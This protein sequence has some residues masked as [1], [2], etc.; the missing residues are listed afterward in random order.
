MTKQLSKNWAN[1]HVVIIGIFHL[2]SG[3]W[4]FLLGATGEEGVIV[5]ASIASEIYASYLIFFGP[6]T[7]VVGILLFF[8]LNFARLS[9][10]FLAWWNLFSGPLLWISWHIYTNN[11]S[12]GSL[13]KWAAYIIGLFLI[14]TSIRI[15]IIRMLNISRAGYVFLKEKAV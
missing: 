8:R 6:I 7:I 2:I 10:I 5:K 13:L 4:Q 14:L 15:Y 3:L 9:A 11:L 12:A 1:F